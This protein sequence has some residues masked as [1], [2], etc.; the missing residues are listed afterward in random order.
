MNEKQG[1]GLLIILSCVILLTLGI[2]IVYCAGF[3]ALGSDT[4]SIANDTCICPP[5]GV[6]VNPIGNVTE[7]TPIT[8]ISGLT[9]VHCGGDVLV[10]I[11]AWSYRASPRSSNPT[12]YDRYVE[13][14][15]V[16][17][18]GPL[19]WWSVDVDTAGLIPGLYTSN[20]L[21][22]GEIGESMSETYSNITKFYVV[23]GDG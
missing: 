2:G 18:D 9:S 20:V 16:A 10:H 6:F 1:I 17:G 22:G 5:H 4:V 15:V 14:K 21:V 7:G 23:D 19:N 8:Q 11:V 12:P 13:T 3:I